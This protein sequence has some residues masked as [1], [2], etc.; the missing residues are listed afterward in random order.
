MQGDLA[1]YRASIRIGEDFTLMSP[2]GGNPTRGAGYTDERWASIA[3]F[4]RNGRASSLEPS[5]S[6]ARRTW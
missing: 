2:F 6:I 1:R 5:G 4:F 3:G